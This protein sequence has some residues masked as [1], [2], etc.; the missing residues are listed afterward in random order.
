M[1]MMRRIA[2]LFFRAK[3]LCVFYSVF[4]LASAGCAIYNI[5]ETEQLTGIL[6]ALNLP[7]S[8]TI[9][10]FVLFAFLSYEFF[11]ATKRFHLDESLRSSQN[12]YRRL[13][14]AQ[15]AFML[16]LVM[17][18]SVLMLAWCLALCVKYQAWKVEFLAHLL[19]NVLLNFCF[20]P[21]CG[22]LL[23]MS[24]ALSA[25]RLNAFLILVLFVL[26][27]SPLANGL[28]YVAL[29]SLRFNLYP[30][31]SMFD[32]FPPNLNWKPVPAFGLS[33]LPYRWALAGFWGLLSLGVVCW[34]LFD[35]RTLTRRLGTAAGVVLSL[36]CLAAA[37]QPAS[38]LLL[39]SDDP[40]RSIMADWEYYFVDQP[41]EKDRETDAAFAITQ[42]DL[43]LSV[44][45]QLKATATITVDQQELPEYLLTL[46]HGYRLKSVS[47][48]EGIAL[49]FKQEGDY[50]TV[51]NPEGRPVK[52]LSLSY[53][54]SSALYYTNVQGVYL[55]GFFPYYPHSGHQP[56]FDRETQGILRFVLK[57]PVLFQIRIHS[58]KTVYS[59]LPTTGDNTFSGRSTGA[60]LLAG[61]Y[62]T[63]T[64][65]GI[66]V[67]YPYLNNWEFRPES[68][69]EFVHTKTGTPPMGDSIKTVL[70]TPDIN[71]ISPYTT[72]CAFSDHLALH[73][74]LGIE[75]SY[76]NQLAGSKKRAL[77]SAYRKYIE[78]PEFIRKFAEDSRDPQATDPNTF[79]A[80]QALIDYLDYF[81]ED[82]G[83]KRVA[84][85]LEDETDNRHWREFIRQFDDEEA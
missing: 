30:F 62:D 40:K 63:L 60:T 28:G 24:L 44:G 53:H 47:T 73:Q 43:D 45:N 5:V 85:Y 51:Q 37:L 57:E 71:D 61:F 26:L 66:T 65:D 32:L 68:L 19:L 33:I 22:L 49:P 75:D 64:V 41:V 84:A 25:K 13:L 69:T 14:T 74:T 79:T 7:L 77:D 82:N 21:C 2:P 56:V 4:L 58:G 27:G 55:P 54:G 39:S 35:R 16:L 72:Y 15:G 29:E 46:Y 52:S 18:F 1:R 48:Q 42:Y 3:A 12:G 8:F 10:S 6:G 31:L 83:R 17:V 23:G 38:K 67:V 9:F 78:N 36:V 80:V 76:L 81:G 11:Y 50:I 70:L 34:K 59:N 20:I